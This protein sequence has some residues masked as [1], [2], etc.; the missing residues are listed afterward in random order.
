MRSHGGIQKKVLTQGENEDLKRKQVSL[1]VGG[2]G[3]R[4]KGGGRGIAG[5]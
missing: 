4:T 1:G 2:G 5:N 3:E